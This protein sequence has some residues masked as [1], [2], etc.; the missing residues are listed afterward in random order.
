MKYKLNEFYEIFNERMWNI[1]E[2]RICTGAERAVQMC[3]SLRIYQSLTNFTAK[4]TRLQWERIKLEIFNG[5][6][7]N[8]RTFMQFRMK[9]F[10]IHLKDAF[11]QVQKEL[12][13][14]VSLSEFFNLWPFLVPRS[15]DCDRNVQNWKYLMD[16]YKLKDIY[17]ILNERTWNTS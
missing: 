9:E 8:W 11:V 2:S 6:N 3:I 14:S 16:E 12:Y 10:E 15:L 13:K 1:S 4:I 7:I 5:G 17:A